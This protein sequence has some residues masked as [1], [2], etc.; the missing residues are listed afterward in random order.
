MEKNIYVQLPRN[1]DIGPN[2]GSFFYHNI[3]KG[4]YEKYNLRRVIYNDKTNNY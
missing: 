4:Y 2:K 1:Y 3:Y